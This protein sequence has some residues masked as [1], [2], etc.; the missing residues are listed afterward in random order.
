MAGL[1][2]RNVDHRE[3]GLGTG[4]DDAHRGICQG[5]CRGDS[6]SSNPLLSP[7]F[8]STSCNLGTIIVSG[9]RVGCGSG[10]RASV[11]VLSFGSRSG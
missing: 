9:R 5:H 3:L 2:S 10:F 4:V 7:M 1:L 6:A 11:V 8:L